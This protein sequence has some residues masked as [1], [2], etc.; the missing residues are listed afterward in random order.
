MTNSKKCRHY[1]CAACNGNYTSDWSKK[2]RNKEYKENFPE[3]QH[4]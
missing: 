4:H 2:E 1:I 3:T